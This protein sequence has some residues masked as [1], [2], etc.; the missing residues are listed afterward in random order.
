[1]CAIVDN[2]VRDQVFGGS[3]SAA[4]RFFLDWLSKGGKL[5]VGGQLLTEL[6]DSTNFRSWFQ[7]AVQAGIVRRVDD[8]EVDK[9]AEQLSQQNVCK[10][11][12][13][14]VLALARIS[15]ARLLFT[16]DRALQIDFGNSDIIYGNARGRIYTTRRTK[17]VTHV[18]RDLLRR[19]DLC[20]G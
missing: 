2:D 17:S 1:M 13:V 18:H 15:G 20:N 5:V 4:G 6:S 12:D 8:D 19:R 14:H 7:Q 3:Q 16:N 10:S 9:Q 11:N